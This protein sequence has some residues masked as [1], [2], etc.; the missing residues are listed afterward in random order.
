MDLIS[1]PLSRS[2]KVR[3]EL[4]FQQNYPSCSDLTS[5][6]LHDQSLHPFDTIGPCY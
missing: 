3:R 1:Q 4:G 2:H 5:V 6:H